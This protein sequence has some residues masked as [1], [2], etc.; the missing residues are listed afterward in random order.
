MTY[1]KS[2]WFVRSALI[3]GALAG[4]VLTGPLTAQAQA[5]ANSAREAVNQAQAQG[6]V[7]EGADGYLAF[8]SRDPVPVDL[9]RNVAAINA[10]RRALYTEYSTTR[11]PAQT[12]EQWAATFAIQQISRMPEGRFLRD[13]S[14]QWCQKTSATRAE[15]ATDGTVV[16]RCR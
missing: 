2:N 4:A 13:M 9:Q 16:I 10:G 1:K 3:A 11:T 6:L 8:V 5:P 15:V 7:G 14:G 12:V